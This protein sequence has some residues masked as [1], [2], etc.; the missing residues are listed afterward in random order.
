MS[1]PHWAHTCRQAFMQ[2]SQE[3][4]E[5][6]N[7]NVRVQTYLDM[8]AANS[9]LFLVFFSKAL[10]WR[11]K[12]WTSFR[13]HWLV[14]RMK[15]QSWGTSSSTWEW[16]IAAYWVSLSSTRDLPQ[17]RAYCLIR[18]PRVM[19]LGNMMVCPKHHLCSQHAS[20]VSMHQPRLSPIFGLFLLE[21][22][23]FLKFA[24]MHGGGERMSLSALNYLL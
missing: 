7:V 2:H 20:W 8:A 19:L 18:T 23:K 9:S 21:G 5:L 24:P 4:T 16:R 22:N 3:C 12:P 10:P 6:R 14:F 11:L 1:V 15:L 17:P 13:V